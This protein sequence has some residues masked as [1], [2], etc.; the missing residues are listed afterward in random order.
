MEFNELPNV[1]SPLMQVCELFN[2]NRQWDRSVI[3]VLLAPW[4]GQEIMAITP[5]QAGQ[6]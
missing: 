5:N 1:V 4:T 2:G 6:D 3:N